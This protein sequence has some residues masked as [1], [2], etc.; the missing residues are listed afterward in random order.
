MNT[1]FKSLAMAGLIFLCACGKEEAL[2]TPL[3]EDRQISAVT[4]MSLPEQLNYFDGIL[5]AG[6][7]SSEIAVRSEEAL[8]VEDGKNGIELMA[9][10][11]FS[12]KP[13]NLG[14]VDTKENTFM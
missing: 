14:R 9:N 6:L 5:R 4:G 10:V 13:A 12:R 7:S 11:Y 2:V 3:N 1:L 8:T